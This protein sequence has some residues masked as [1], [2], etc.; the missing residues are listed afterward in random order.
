MLALARRDRRG[1]PAGP[2]RPS[3]PT[4]HGPERGPTPLQIF[5]PNFSKWAMLDDRALV[6]TKARAPIRVMT[7]CQCIFESPL[8]SSFKK[9][10]TRKSKSRRPNGCTPLSAKKPLTE[11]AFRWLPQDFSNMAAV[12]R[13]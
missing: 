10:N 4:S 9:K 3:Q 12:Q 11:L 8:F 6:V 13:A 1:P 5:P 2:G 7:P